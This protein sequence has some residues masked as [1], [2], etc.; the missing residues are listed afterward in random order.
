M[1]SAKVAPENSSGPPSVSKGS[2]DLAEGDRICGRWVVEFD[3]AAQGALLQVVLTVVLAALHVLIMTATLLL[4]S[5]G[6]RIIT[7]INWFVGFDFY[8]ILVSAPH[9]VERVI[10]S[11]SA[12]S[13]YSTAPRYRSSASVLV[14][15][16]LSETTCGVSSASLS[17]TP[18]VPLTSSRA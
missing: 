9:F 7:P 3:M 12:T 1:A 11:L 14:P 5:W 6:G 17:G 4:S 13:L 2:L 10:Q 18:A 16:S 15:E 8:S